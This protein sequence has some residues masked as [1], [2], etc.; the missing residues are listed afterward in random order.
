M[1]ATL[2]VRG[3]VEPYTTQDVPD[4]GDNT[5]DEGLESFRRGL[6]KSSVFVVFTSLVIEKIG[7]DLNPSVCV[8]LRVIPYVYST[9]VKFLK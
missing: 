2:I 3:V 7:S 4:S 8:N 1:H 9:C 5:N 6:S